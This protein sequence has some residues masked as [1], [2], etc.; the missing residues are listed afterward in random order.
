MKRPTIWIAAEN[1][2]GFWLRRID[3]FSIPDSGRVRARIGKSEDLAVEGDVGECWI[4]NQ[5]EAGI[6]TFCIDS[7]DAPSVLLPCSLSLSQEW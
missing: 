3:M 2:K 5:Q 1:G 6:L 7:S 4:W